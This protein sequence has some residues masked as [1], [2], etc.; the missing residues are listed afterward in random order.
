MPPLRDGERFTVAGVSY[1]NGQWRTD[2]A[3]G[4]ETQLVAVHARYD[5]DRQ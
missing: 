1:R 5:P 4:E 3:P 2:C